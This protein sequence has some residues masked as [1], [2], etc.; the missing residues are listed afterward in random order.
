MDGKREGIV[1]IVVD[2]INSIRP[3][4]DNNAKLKAI[5][6]FIREIE[7]DIYGMS[8]VRVNWNQVQRGQAIRTAL[9]RDGAKV[10]HRAQP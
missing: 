1:R 4:H 5:R 8:E 3:Q 10:R 7:A 9:V 2:N 6:Q